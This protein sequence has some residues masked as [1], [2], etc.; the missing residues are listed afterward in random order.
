MSKLI[1]DSLESRTT[2]KSVDVDN[3]ANGV[4]R[5]W[6]NFD[7]TTTPPTIRASYNVSSVVRDGTGLYTVNF[8]NPMPDALYCTVT[9]SKGAAFTVE[10]AESNSDVSINYVQLATFTAGSSLANSPQINAAI[11]R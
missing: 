7:G 2:E 6:V 11:F 3:V 9:R 4:A 10:G 5:A 1:A 8:T